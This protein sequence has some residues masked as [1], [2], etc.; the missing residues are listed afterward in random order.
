MATY[1]I[2]NP[3]DIAPNY[4]GR[5]TVE[6]NIN[7]QQSTLHLT[8]VNA[9]DSRIYQC[10]VMILNDGEGTTSATTSLMVLG[11]N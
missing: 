10:S 11:E 6:V 5:A 9:L 4:E 8:N 2:N 7:T 1:F 3:V